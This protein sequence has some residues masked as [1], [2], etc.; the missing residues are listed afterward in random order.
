MNSDFLPELSCGRDSS[1][2]MYE[3]LPEGHKI[4]RRLV[5][6]RLYCR[7]SVPC[8]SFC[9]RFGF[10]FCKD[11]H[12]THRSYA[13]NGRFSRGFRFGSVALTLSSFSATKHWPH[14]NRFLRCI[15]RLSNRLW[16]IRLCMAVFV[17]APALH[18]IE[19]TGFVLST[20][21]TSFAVA[22]LKCS[23]RARLRVT[24]ITSTSPNVVATATTS[25]R[26]SVV[27]RSIGKD[28]P[29]RRERHPIR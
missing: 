25:P 12:A 17:A 26:V 24:V 29:R 3:S 28:L 11:T 1:N 16:A 9:D 23:L 20:L 15:R 13:I 18:A 21:G 6:S 4:Y 10:C 2:D 7:D 27:D 5:L 14:H 22:I 19:R 8:D